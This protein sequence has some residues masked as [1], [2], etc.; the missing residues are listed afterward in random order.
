MEIRVLKEYE[1][2][3]VKIILKNN[4]VYSGIYFTITSD[5]LL[6]FEDRNKE[7][8]RLEPSFVVMIVEINDGGRI[9]G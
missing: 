6:E 7:I 8:I 3:R 1:S 5:G 2:K 9:N 4:F